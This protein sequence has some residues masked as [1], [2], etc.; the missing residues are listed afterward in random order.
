ME[1]RFRKIKNTTQYNEGIINISGL[2][3]GRTAPLLSVI[4]KECE[5]PMF[6]ITSTQQRAKGLYEDL[7]FLASEKEIYLIPEDEKI[8]LNYEAK[9][10]GFLEQRLKG[11]IKLAEGKSC[12]VIASAGAALRKIMPKEAFVQHSI[13]L[14]VDEEYSIDELKRLFA[15]LG[16]EKTHAIDIKGQY[17]VR[18]DIV[19]IYPYDREYPVRIE[20][21]DD[22]VDSVRE[23]DPE[24]QRSIRTLEKVSVYP[25]VQIL[26]SEETGQK[27]CEKIEKA[28]SRQ[29]GKLEREEADRLNQ[30]KGRIIENIQTGSNNQSLSNYVKYFYEETDTLVDYMSEKGI[31]VVEDY[32][33][34]RERVLLSE[35]EL[36][37]DFKTLLERG[38]SVPEEL[39]FYIKSSDLFET[40][41][42]QKRLTYIITP[43]TVT[44]KGVEALREVISV[45]AKALPSYA[46]KMEMFLE[47]VKAY[48]KKGFEVVVICSGEERRD[49]LRN[50]LSR[51]SAYA[52]KVLVGKLTAG[53]EYTDEKLVLVSDGDIFTSVKARKTRKQ[54]KNAK[55]IK[56]FVDIKR[57]DYVVHENHGI[58]KFIEIQQLEIEGVKRDYLKIKYAGED[59]LYVPVD[60]MDSVQKYVG[61]ETSTVKINKLSGSE[62]KKTKQ[63]VRSAIEQMAREIMELS[64]QRR[65]IP[66]FAF[67]KDSLW[68]KEF[69][70][71]F[72]YAETDDQIKCTEEI[73]RDMEEA[74]PMERLL[75]GDVGYGKT[76]V[77]ARAVFK[78]I[79]D[80]KQAAILVP[81]TILA[82]QHYSTFK[83]RLEPFPFTVEMLSRFRTEKQQEKII[84]DLKKG[85]VDVIIGTHRLLSKDI[86]FNDLGL[87]IIDEEQRFGVQHKEAI[88]MLR[89]NVDVLTLSATPIPRTLHMSLIGARDMSIIEEPPEERYPVQTYVMEQ[90][91][92]IIRSAIMSEMD[93][94]GQTFVVFNRVKDIR[95][96]AD[97]IRALVPEAVVSVGHGRMSEDSLENVIIDFIEQKS[98]VLVCTTIIETGVDIPNANTMIILDADRF[99]L[100]QLYQLRGRVGRSNKMAYAYLMYQKNKVLT[101][102]AEKRLTAIKDFTELGA[103]FKLAMRDLELRGAGNILGTE[104]SGH[105]VTVGYELYCKLMEETMSV[106][107]GERV[108][109]ELPE[110]TLELDFNAYLPEKYIEDETQRI[111]IYQKIAEI[112]TD[113]DKMEII[114][115]LIDR[116]GDI[117]KAV[118]NLILV[119]QIKSIAK[120][121][122]IEKVS[123]KSG[124]VIL[125]FLAQNKLTAEMIMNMIQKV[126]GKARVNAGRKPFIKY[127]IGDNKRKA[128]EI[129]ELVKALAVGKTE[130]KEIKNVK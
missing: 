99:G 110:T 95:R 117:P 111:E 112:H 107:K 130:L 129:L 124:E 81:T 55:P 65:A 109:E 69:E 43:F 120:E 93:R 18:G 89:K 106:L 63:K 122:G 126:G 46:G 40:V 58:G 7:S 8:F 115:E 19:D 42:K 76:E 123:E 70:D 92:D 3:E 91:D 125:T 98:D 74:V 72:P 41:N 39:D 103:G 100:S 22:I 10:R 31:L 61:G 105:M 37:E 64:A 49:N 118:Q 85:K 119:G 75:C 13:T 54:N 33:R 73:K 66:G 68:Q 60:Q 90:D 6:I 32:E 114:D 101:E 20:F 1:H 26:Y 12:I 5:R 14:M 44:L 62:W 102:V 25:A 17:S 34:V 77:A 87:L 84:D 57:G 11:V 113:K 78:C 116:F 9:S 79:A 15:Q 36:R 121:I 16:Y 71:A 67:S 50:Y 4:S 127:K 88:K 28:Y 128:E 2:S 48:K 104:Q 29:A 30:R 56:S 94:G 96:V 108:P 82:S 86:V 52:D 23:F 24:T 53:T 47:D 97:H 27:A 21:F 83:E 35:K 38:E 51:N 59:M 80:G 45:K